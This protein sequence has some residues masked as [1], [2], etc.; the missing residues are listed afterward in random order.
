MAEQERPNP[1]FLVVSLS[2]PKRVAQIEKQLAASIQDEEG[3]CLMWVGDTNYVLARSAGKQLQLKRTKDEAAAFLKSIDGVKD[4]KPRTAEWVMKAL[5]KRDPKPLLDEAA[6]ESGR[7]WNL[8]MVRARQAWA[9]IPGGLPAKAWQTI[10]VGHIDTGYTEH[11]VFG[12]EADGRS[13]AVRP[14]EGIDYLDGGLPRD[15][16]DYSGHPGH[17][18]RTSSVLAGYVA[19]EFLGVAP[20]VT[21]IPYRITKLVLIDSIFGES[22]LD[23]AIEHAAIDNACQVISIS[24]GDPCFPP[25]DVGRA[26]DKAYRDGVIVVAAAGNVTS[27]VTYPGRYART[28]C[29][30]GVTRSKRPWTGGSRGSRVD[31][32]APADDIYRAN[33]LLDDGKV[34]FSYATDGSGTSYATVHLAGAAALWRA[35]HGNS[36]DRYPQGW[37][38]VEAFRLLA[39]QTAQRPADWNDQLFGAGILDIEALLNAPLPHESQLTKRPSA[40]DVVF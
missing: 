11:P 16:L 35:F 5:S 37:Q 26:I 24:L 23:R 14:H 25:S 39:R 4:A 36:L 7:Q 38:I 2:D 29:A 34:K 9:L 6:F 22:K 40:E 32:C 18:T 12:F 19:R 1:S 20:H 15:P 8:N 21:V 13:P 33:A 27:E 10:R 30:G 31:L 3:R 17:G 28:I